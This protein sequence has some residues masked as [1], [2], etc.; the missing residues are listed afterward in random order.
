MWKLLQN[1]PDFRDWTT[2]SVITIHS[3]TMINT[4]EVLLT[5][6]RE[7]LRA[8][9]GWRCGCGARGCGLS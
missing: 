8:V 4:V 6:I 2:S 5:S 9:T 7:H 3:M 1:L